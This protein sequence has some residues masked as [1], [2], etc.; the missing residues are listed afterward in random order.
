[1]SGSTATCHASGHAR[2]E[3]REQRRERVR[4]WKTSR[5]RAPKLAPLGCYEDLGGSAG[6]QE[7]ATRGSGFEHG[8][9]QPEKPPYA[10]SGAWVF[11]RLARATLPSDAK[12]ATSRARC[13]IRSWARLT[14]S[15]V[16]AALGA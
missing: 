15:T 7:V 2:G 14:R 5:G 9:G 12:A 1:M 16:R 4:A 10:K 11:A 3:T 6:A 13:S 8:Q